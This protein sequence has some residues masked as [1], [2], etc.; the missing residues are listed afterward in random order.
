MP[1]LKMMGNDKVQ[2]DLNATAA[3]KRAGYKSKGR[4]A[5]NAASRLLVNVGIAHAIQTELSK[6]EKRSAATVDRLELE[7]ERLAL[8]DVRKL[9]DSDGA[10]KPVTEWDDDLAAAIAGLWYTK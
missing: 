9:F 7:L 10:L 3:Y 1:R 8:A 6:R 5:E 2:A 4:A